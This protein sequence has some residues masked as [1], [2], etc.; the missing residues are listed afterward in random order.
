M[1]ES[2]QHIIISRALN[3]SHPTKPQEIIEW[4]EQTAE[5]WNKAPTAF[6]WGGKRKAR[7][8]RAKQ[9]RRS[10]ALAKS[11]GYTQEPV[12][13]HQAQPQHQLWA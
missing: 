13:L 11:G 9:R 10:H 7:R 3:G 6:E 1:A 2:I 12:A 4:L 5:G 8:E